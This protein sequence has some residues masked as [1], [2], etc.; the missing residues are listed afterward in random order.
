MAPPP[1]RKAAS[2]VDVPPGDDDALGPS[3]S[4]DDQGGVVVSPTV[5]PPG[6]EEPHSLIGAPLDPIDVGEDW[7]FTLAGRIQS[8]RSFVN[9]STG[10]YGVKAV[11]AGLSWTTN[12]VVSSTLCVTGSDQ[13][14]A[15][16]IPVT[17]SK[18]WLYDASGN[19]HRRASLTG[20]PVCD[21]DTVMLRNLVRNFSSGGH[22]T[23]PLHE[24]R[25][26]RD[27]STKVRG[28]RALSVRDFD[29]VYNATVALKKKEAMEML[30]GSSLSEG[31]VV[32]LEV[33]VTRYYDKWSPDKKPAFDSWK[34]SFKMDSVY[35]LHQ[36]VDQ[37]RV[38][39]VRAQG[40]ADFEL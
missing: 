37:P 33:T 2:S 3:A 25:A 6:P 8:L 27:Q 16:W 28:E 21:V 34:V 22:G 30:D 14:L 29:Q 7:P 9:V 35:V 12:R 32:V 38:K 18:L 1:K 20:T 23:E 26:S 31:D 10:V 4:A 15:I 24:I 17:I 11:P 40:V 19:P 39:R 36:G 5:P 13:P